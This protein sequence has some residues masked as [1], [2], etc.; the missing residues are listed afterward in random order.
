MKFSNPFKQQQKP[1]K[2]LSVYI[3][4]YL[5][6]TRRAK[7]YKQVF[8]NIIRHLDE[9]SSHAGLA[10]NTNSFTEQFSEEFLDYLRG[11]QLM[12][13]TVRNIFRRVST[14][15]NRAARDGYLVDTSYKYITVEDE[16]SNAIYL[17]LDEL[18]RLNEL[19]GLSKEAKAVRD[20]FLVG[21]FTA[22]RIS[23]Y[24]R[25]SVENNFIG[26]FIQIKTQKTGVN[27]IGRAHV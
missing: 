7:T 12:K 1:I 3:R 27:E 17:T 11:K 10:V 24:R 6:R 15:L 16:Y 25:L 5:V 9:F 23:D 2:V 21:C 4:E 8:R 22:L 19:K 20:R 14:M 18:K 13:S 26:D